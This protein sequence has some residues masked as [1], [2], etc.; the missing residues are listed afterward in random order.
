MSGRRDPAEGGGHLPAPPTPRRAPLPALR[1]HRAGEQVTK[2]RDR[3]RTSSRPGP[4]ASPGA[5]PYLGAGRDGPAGPGEDWAG[6]TRLPPPQPLEAKAGAG[7]GAASS[8]RA[9]AGGA[10]LAA[11]AAGAR[12]SELRGRQSPAAAAL[13][14]P[15]LREAGCR[16]GKLFR[17]QSRLRNAA[18]SSSSPSHLPPASFPPLP[19]LPAGSLLVARRA[20]AAT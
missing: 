13:V 6:E 18:A 12:V 4:P 1:V 11:A 10:A 20:L 15:L 9:A 2:S 3:T 19:Q 17:T 16:R 5:A 7:A 8:S 14:P